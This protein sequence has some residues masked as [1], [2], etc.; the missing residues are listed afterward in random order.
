MRQKKD[1]IWIKFLEAGFVGL[2]AG[3]IL[4]LLL[5]RWVWLEMR[6]N[7]GAIIPCSIVFFLI[8]GFWKKFNISVRFLLCL[9]AISLLAFFSLYG[10][11]LG[12]LAFVPA[13]L[14]REGC[15][16]TSL[17]ISSVNI[18]LGVTLILG[19]SVIIFSGLKSD[20]RLRGRH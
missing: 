4:A 10:F 13:C 20:T 7:I 19:N 12:A 5:N 14:F 1:S 15:N 18:L 6:I 16:V 17:D 9:E 11:K 2:I 8:L 3:Y